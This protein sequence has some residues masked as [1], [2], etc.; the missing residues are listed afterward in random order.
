MDAFGY[1]FDKQGHEFA[2]QVVM[3]GRAKKQLELAEKDYIAF[4]KAH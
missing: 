2:L 4:L 1:D 3:T